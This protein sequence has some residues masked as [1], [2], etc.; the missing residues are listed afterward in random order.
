MFILKEGTT[1]KITASFL[2]GL[3]HCPSKCMR[4]ALTIF[5]Q[6]V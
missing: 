2:G 5:I 3:G 4:T 6:H 1:P